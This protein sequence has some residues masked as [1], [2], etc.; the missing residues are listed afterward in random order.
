MSDRPRLPRTGTSCPI[1]LSGS[2]I[3]HG[4]ISP[5]VG[6]T[7]LEPANPR[8]HDRSMP[9]IPERVEHAQGATP[10]HTHAGLTRFSTDALGRDVAT[11]QPC[12]ERWHEIA[13]EGLPPR[14]E[15]GF[16]W[17]WDGNG[18]VLNQWIGG[19]DMDNPEWAE[20]SLQK[21]DRITHWWPL[22]KPAPPPKE[23]R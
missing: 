11:T 1:C 17:T 3:I 18:I 12:S 8:D 13:T 2:G 19:T 7:P 20:D 23:P 10:L 4:C 22:V 5:L 21:S 14:T 16:H 15:D 9:I 6:Y